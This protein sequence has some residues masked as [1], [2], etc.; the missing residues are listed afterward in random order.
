M[1]WLDSVGGFFEGAGKDIV[2]AAQDG[3]QAA[4]NGW[5][6]AFNAAKA[7]VQ[8]ADAA[9]AQ[10]GS[11]ID[12]GEQYVEHKVDEGRAWLRQHGGVAGQVASDYIGFEEGVDLSVYGAGKGLVQL[13]DGAGSLTNPVEW[14]FNPSANIA[15]VQSTIKS[16]EALGKI[17]SLTEPSS[18]VAD[19]QGNMRLVSALS[20]SVAKSFERDPAK[21]T[22]NVTGTVAMFFIPGA[23]VASAV[24]DTGRTAELLC[25]AG[26]ITDTVNATDDAGRTSE[27]TDGLARGGRA[28]GGGDVPTDKPPILND[29]WNPSPSDRTLVVGGGHEFRQPAAGEVFLNIDPEA[30][31]DIVADMRNA[32][33]I[34]ND[35]FSEVYFERVEYDVMAEQPPAALAEA[36][37]V[38]KP[39]GTL[40]LSTGRDGI[41]GPIVSRL[42]IDNLKNVGFQN[43]RAI[44]SQDPITGARDWTFRATKPAS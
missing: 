7:A 19:P 15:R 32:P 34:P 31:P 17:A 29:P 5:D 9:K 33:M 21:F 10:V 14:V 43:V 44:V 12:S 27:L 8:N 13:A 42:I 16:G 30:R 25:D 18:W 6:T 26:K 41:A 11:L 38:L 1:G 24:G 20:S 23:D 39:G 22:G 37:R 40:L 4:A 2:H 28:G 36:Y 35:H 3:Y